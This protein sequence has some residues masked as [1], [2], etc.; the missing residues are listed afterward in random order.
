MH[1]LVFAAGRGT[2]LRPYTD[3]TPK[4]L[5]EVGGEPLL[6]RCVRAVVD[7]GVEAITIVV[8]YR[9]EEIVDRFGDDVGGVSITYAHQREREGLAHAV[10]AA[11]AHVE[12][13]VLAVNGDNVFDGDLSTLVE[14][15]RESDVDGTVLLDRGSR[16]EAETAGLCDVAPDGTIRAVEASLESPEA[17]RIAAG[18][19]THS[20]ALFDACRAIERADSGEY[21][22]ADALQYLVDRGRRYVGVELE[23]WH[24]N[25]NTPSDLERARRHLSES[26]G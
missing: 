16:N 10:L 4:P 13:D 19:Q 17:G 14:R 18:A 22:L 3:E 1:G 7:A 12:G 20:P 25:V 15:H 11:E 6:A 2:R 9:S 24:L 21:E 8:G 23:G 5:L 26:S